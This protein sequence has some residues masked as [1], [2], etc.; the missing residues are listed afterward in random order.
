MKRPL[1]SEISQVALVV[2]DLDRATRVLTQEL[3]V[4]PLLNLRFGSVEG[5]PT[6]AENA[7]ALPIDNYYL[8][9]EYIGRYG[10]F[11]AAATF[12]NEVQLEMISPA[13]NRSLFRDYLDSHGPGVQH[14]CIKHGRDYDGYLKLLG[15]MAVAGNPLTSICRVDKEEICAFVDHDQRLG[16]SLEVQFRP[17]TYQLPD[18]APPMLQPNRKACPKPLAGALTGMTIAAWRMEPV[19]ELLEKQYGIGPWEIGGPGL[20]G[21]RDGIYTEIRTAT[22][23]ALNLT[24][25]I[26][27]PVHPEDGDDEAVRFLRK[28]GGNGV[29]SVHFTAPEGV[30]VLKSKRRVLFGNDHAVLLDFTE[31]LGAYLKF[32]DSSY[33]R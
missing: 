19:L 24:L 10:I 33:G 29:F 15:E 27:E 25:E 26:F 11:M 8:R 5:D 2:S 9:G 23:K 16:L 28:N 22:C 7:V 21:F 12:E 17:E 14:I 30:D 31:E 20:H 13:Q 3:G 32:I 6:F 18:M 1:F 4:G